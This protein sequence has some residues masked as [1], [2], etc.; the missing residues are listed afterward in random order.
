MKGLGNWSVL[1][2]KKGLGMCS[3]SDPRE[4]L[5]RNFGSDLRKCPFLTIRD[6]VS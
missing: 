4:G 3:K 2:G 6:Y 1:N 5:E